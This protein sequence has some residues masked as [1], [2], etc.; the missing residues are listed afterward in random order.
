MPSATVKVEAGDSADAAEGTAAPAADADEPPVNVLQP[1]KKRARRSPSSDEDLPPPPPPMPTIRLEVDL[2]VGSE[3]P[4]D[5]NFIDQAALA[6]HPVLNAWGEA[7][8]L[9][10]PFGDP[11]EL[12]A[13][14]GGV[15]GEDTPMTEAT[16]DVPPLS[17]PPPAGMSEAE[18]REMEAI[19]AR[20]EAKYEDKGKKK[21]GRFCQH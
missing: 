2:P 1:K 14:A 17:G 4:L 20:L 7:P 19:A 11:A 16:G 12:R 18:V 15:G 6:G 10:D 9:G 13:G 8:G 5:W 21:V 3:E